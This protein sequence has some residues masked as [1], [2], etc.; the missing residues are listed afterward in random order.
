MEFI[1]PLKIGFTIY[2]KSNCINCSTIKKIIKE[3]NL[4][5]FEVNCD[6]YILENREK[7]LTFIEERAETSYKTFPMVFYDCKFVGGMA[8]TKE[9]IDKLLSFEDVF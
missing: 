5:F 1:E 8:H 2:S 9:F 6:E 3:K 4:F 7:F